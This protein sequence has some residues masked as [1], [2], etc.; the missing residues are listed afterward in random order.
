LSARG[1][2]ILAAVLAAGCGRCGGAS[3]GSAE[4][5]SRTVALVQGEPI[6]SEAVRRE[7]AQAIG[8]TATMEGDP[9]VAR[10]RVLED[11]VDRALLLQEARARSI[12]VGED[13]VERAFL[14]VRSEYPGS[15][16]DDLLAKERLSQ[17]EL[18][19]R[20]KEQLTI[21][22]LFHD[23][24]FPQLRVTDAEVERYFT[25]H[26]AEFQA[27][28]MVRVSQIVVATRDEAA[29]L[30]DR[31]RREPQ[32]FADLAR[33]LSIAPEGKNGGDLGF[34]VRGGGF[35]EVFDLCFT[36]PRNVVSDVTPSPYGFHLFKVTDKKPAQRQ[37]LE[38]V[39]GQ[40]LERLSRE[41]RA[42]AQVEYL[43]TLRKR[44]SIE[45]D[46]KAL[47]TVTP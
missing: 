8:G 22:K 19:A 46:E 1:L 40:I 2:A 36:L 47:A 15:H 20:L 12:V 30:R 31:L 18:R 25:D 33:R 43:A 41:K 26:A 45:I 9:A 5:G 39:R 29:Q 21:E 32:N 44:A 4:P 28:E 6:T 38:Q 10:R 3:S 34:I 23:E 42:R 13:Q 37:T 14:R 17:S 16:F 7:L 24:V 35:P 27:P 11:L